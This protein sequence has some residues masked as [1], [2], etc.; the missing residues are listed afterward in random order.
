MDTLDEIERDVNDVEDT[1]VDT[2]ENV[3]CM[4]ASVC[5]EDTEE[6]IECMVASVLRGPVAKKRKSYS[7]ET[8]L[9]AIQYY[10]ECNN[11]YHTAKNFNIKP[12][13]FR[14]WLKNAAKIKE[15]LGK[16]GCGRKA[17]W[18]D[19]EEESYRQYKKLRSEGLKVKGWLFEA[20]SEEL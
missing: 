1:E 9:A 17:F 19:M 13:T 6:N 7:R 20:K 16:V 10:H 14:G 18:P 2:E 3:E 11:K 8:K 4:A 15:V 5:E 12:S